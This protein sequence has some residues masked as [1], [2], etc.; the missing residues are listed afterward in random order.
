M[1]C[2]CML[3]CAESLAKTIDVV[4]L[5]SIR[6]YKIYLVLSVYVGLLVL[7]SGITKGVGLLVTLP[8]LFYTNH[9]AYL[10]VREKVLARGLGGRC[11]C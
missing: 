1:L 8:L 7:A 6:Y 2:A 11:L 3:K 10:E 5:S 4:G 9:F